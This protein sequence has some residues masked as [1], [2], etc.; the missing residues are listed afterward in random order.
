[1]TRSL[2]PA[3]HL[4][5]SVALALPAHAQEVAAPAAPG[6]PGGTA[7]TANAAENSGGFGTA[8]KPTVKRGTKA[9]TPAAPYTP[10]QSGG[11]DGQIAEI[12]MFVGESRVFPAPG[13]ARI[14]V[15]NG[16]LLSAAALD[17]KEV[18]LFANGEGTSSLFI[19]NADGRYQRVKINIVAGDTSRHAREIAAFLSTIPN[20]RTSIIGA[21]IVVEGEQLSDFDLE[22][23][24]ALS[25][26]YPQIVNFTNRVGW[27][28]MVSM[29]VKVVEF[30]TSVLKEVGLKWTSTGGGAV[31]AIWGPYRRNNDGPY[32]ID[33]RTGTE[34]PP[35]ISSPDGSKGVLVPPGLNVLSVLNLGLNAQLS[36]LAQ[37]GK[38]TLLAEPQLSARNGAKASF[39]AGG[40]LPYAV[41]NRDGTTILFKPYGIKVDITPRVDASGVIRATIESEVSSIDRSVTTTF[42]PALLTRKTNTEF[43][44]RD[45]ETLVLSGLL[46]RD[47]STDIDKVPLLGDIPILGALFRSKRFQNKETELVVFV[48]PRVVAADSPSNRDRIAQ[49]TE[50][51]QA[52]MGPTPYLTDPLQ[53][54]VSYEKADKVP[55][56]PGQPPA[57][58]A[59]V[60][61]PVTA[62]APLVAGIGRAPE[63][64]LLRVQ[65]AQA[66]L[67]AQPIATAEALLTLQRG[68]TVVLGSAPSQPAGQGRWTNVHV[69]SINGWVPSEAIVAWR[70]TDAGQPDV[71]PAVIKPVPALK[72]ALLGKTD[73]ELLGTP[74]RVQSE[75]LA[76]RVTPDVNAA[77]VWRAQR[78]D[79]V[80][81]LN[82]P[83][84]GAWLPVQIGAGPT[85]KRGWVMAQW[86]VPLNMP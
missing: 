69:G 40:E 28:K 78:G 18:I 67:R 72:P 39:L 11:N 60:P 61:E 15:G 13:V 14:A 55:Q 36:L 75:A 2:A 31:G 57:D 20:A 66:V 64:A 56:R 82:L 4:C 38:A 3:L 63:G 65:T 21:N 10:I 59:P 5:L 73:D 47:S 7:A 45:G 1:M 62:E 16:R 25:K 84:Q 51:L 19:W 12:D 53:P 32:Q 49:T 24:E 35:P 68:A 83:P 23:I 6:A 85:G 34:N 43:N 80:R 42:G 77:V 8:L 30:P 76:L 29:D 71:R 54:G 26:R 41:S 46:Q 17:E 9:G 70:P 22:K 58:N 52:R 48:T 79:V 50:R 37:D 27:E 86:L 33:I 74:M 81:R 44:L